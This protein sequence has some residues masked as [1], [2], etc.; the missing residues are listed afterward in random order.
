MTLGN[1]DWF[2]IT[3]QAGG[4]GP[5]VALL[6][7]GAALSRALLCSCYFTQRSLAEASHMAKL[8]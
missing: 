5:A 7:E 3:L 6:P 2:S 1:K 8:L 4:G